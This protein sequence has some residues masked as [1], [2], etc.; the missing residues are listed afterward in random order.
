M[1]YMF[2]FL[3]SFKKLNIKKTIFMKFFKKL[4]IKKKLKI[5]TKYTKTLNFIYSLHKL[6]IYI[7]LFYSPIYSLINL[8][9]K[10]FFTNFNIFY[11]LFT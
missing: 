3:K 1:L 2:F 10:S 6:Y 4:N 8:D 9:V 5:I 11:F 7:E